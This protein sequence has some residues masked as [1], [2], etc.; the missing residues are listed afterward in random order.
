VERLVSEPG[1][2]LAKDKKNSTDHS[3]AVKAKVALAAVR[4]FNS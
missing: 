3:A 2:I 1:I 4:G